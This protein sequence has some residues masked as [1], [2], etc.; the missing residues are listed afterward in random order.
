MSKKEKGLTIIELLITISIFMGTIVV[1]L[2]LGSRAIS[3]T[4][5]LF[6]Q[7]QA[8][9]LAEEGIEILKDDAIR[10]SIKSQMGGESPTFWSIDYEGTIEKKSSLEGCKENLK[11][12]SEGFYN[13]T[14]NKESP[15]SRCIT[16]WEDGEALK[17][18]TKT[19]FFY[20]G[21]ERDVNLYRIFYE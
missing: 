17:V 21:E 14:G 13:L 1:V 6:L 19:S 18:K 9:F 4:D 15:F 7:T 11:E 2:G 12:N 5:Y 16:V 10:S 8:V 3:E 20:K